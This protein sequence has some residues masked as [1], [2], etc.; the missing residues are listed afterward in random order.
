MS[1]KEIGRELLKASRRRDD[2]LLDLYQKRIREI[3]ENVDQFAGLKTRLMISDSPEV[4]D[5]IRFAAFA[6]DLTRLSFEP[7]NELKVKIPGPGALFGGDSLKLTIRADQ[8]EKFAILNEQAQIAPALILRTDDFFKRTMKLIAPLMM[9]GRLIVE[10]VRGVLIPNNIPGPDGRAGW[11]MQ[12]VDENSPYNEWTLEG[13]RRSANPSIPLVQSKSVK[14]GERKLYEVTI[15]FLAGIGFVDL[16]R[17][18]EDEHHHLADTRLALREVVNQAGDNDTPSMINDLIRPKLDSLERRFKSISNSHSLRQG[19]AL[20]G[21]ATVALMAYA[22][23]GIPQ[24]LSMAAGAGGLGIMIKQ[25][26]DFVEKR[27]AIKE[28]PL[29]LLWRL[30]G[31]RRHN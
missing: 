22:A 8:A 14:D 11:D 5:L 17:V 23:G 31:I 21:T 27:D 6:N 4:L 3:H 13:V 9:N 29:Y 2:G 25:Q 19:G 24:A 7:A 12:S 20:L 26:S 1:F 15:P 28:D 16:V 10:P 18:L 30:G